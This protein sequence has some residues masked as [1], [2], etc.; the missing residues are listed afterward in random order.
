MNNALAAL[1]AE[2]QLLEMEELPPEHAESIQRAVG[3]CRLAVNRSRALD[4]V[5]VRELIEG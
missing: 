4:P 1:F 3:L 2:L 5:P